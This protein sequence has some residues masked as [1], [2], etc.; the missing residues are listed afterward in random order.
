MKSEL[1][2]ISTEI[3]FSAEPLLD[4]ARSEAVC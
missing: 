3:K 2:T 4:F 1:E